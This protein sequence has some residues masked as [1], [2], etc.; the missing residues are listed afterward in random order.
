VRI[1]GLDPGTHTGWALW[2]TERFE[3]TEVDSK[4]LHIAMFQLH[5]MRIGRTAP[6]LVIME[7]A[8]L[9][10]WFGK[11]DQDEARAGSAR[12]EGAG[13]AKRDATIWD[14]Y[15]TDV[16]IPF[17]K[18]KPSGTKRPADEFKRLSGWVEPT[19]EHGRD[20]GMLVLQVNT[21]MAT[22]M[23]REAREL[24]LLA[25]STRKGPIRASTKQSE[26]NFQ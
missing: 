2:D 18:R 7:D 8:R 5:H 14:D 11:A 16:G 23:L 1:L 22:Q 19:N 12:R 24:Y 15:L 9:R 25:K 6:D 17:L 21:P 26:R 10:K 20:A 4:R 3:F 13:A